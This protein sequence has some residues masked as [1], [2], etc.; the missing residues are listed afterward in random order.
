MRL[1]WAH[2]GLLGLTEALHCGK[3]LLMT[4]IYGDQFLNAY[5][6]QDRGIGLKLDYQDI[7]VEMLQE[8]LQEL[9]KPR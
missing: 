6:A 3:P 1:F 2:A 4:P 5:A 9:S 7:N 8:S